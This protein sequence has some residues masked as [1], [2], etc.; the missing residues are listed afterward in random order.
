MNIY[1]LRMNMLLTTNAIKIL[2][3]LLRH[4]ESYNVNQIAR[5]LYISVGSAHKI[6][7][8]LREKQV[9]QVREMGNAIYYTLNFASTE[10][11]KSC[12]LILIKEKN[13]LLI[14]NKTAKV[15]VSDLE[16]YPAQSIVLF[17]SIL[18]PEKSARDVDVLFIIKRKQEVKAVNT[19]CLEISALRTKKVNPLIM[20]ER[21]FSHNLKNNNKAILAIVQTGLILKGEDV[22][23][24][25]IKNAR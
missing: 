20:L 4:T 17:G 5:T 16:K 18:S 10:A 23:I 19:F 12:E 14:E 8:A 11:V 6:L 22:F 2:D 21:D 1:S 24:T 3:F 9:V 15:Y 13:Q 7:Q 25:A